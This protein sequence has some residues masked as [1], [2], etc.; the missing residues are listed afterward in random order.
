MDAYKEEIFGPV[1]NVLCV[2]T[3]EEAI[4]LINANPYG[5]GTAIFTTNGTAARKYQH[6]IDVGQV[7]INVPIPVPLPHFSFTGSRASIRGDLNFYGKGGI[8]FYTQLK[9]ITSLWRGTDADTK[10]AHT[11]MPTMK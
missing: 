10:G 7:G 6:E 5:N 3:M 9:T 8:Q 1:L 11:V 2:D 4:E